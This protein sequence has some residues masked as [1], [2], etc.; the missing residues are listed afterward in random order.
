MS[1]E[2]MYWR[3]CGNAGMENA[4]RAS[5]GIG[6]GKTLGNIRPYSMVMFT[7]ALVI[8]AP[9]VSVTEPENVIPGCKVRSRFVGI[10]S[11]SRMAARLSFKLRAKTQFVGQIEPAQLSVSRLI[12]N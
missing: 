6:L 12:F 8:G 2:M 10:R 11:N 5:T 3:P 4:P 7:T 1:S 9:L